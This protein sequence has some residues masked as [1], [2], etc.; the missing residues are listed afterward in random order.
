MATQA[1]LRAPAVALETVIVE[2]RALLGDRVSTTTATREQHGHDESWHHPAMPDAVCFVH[3]TAEVAA[4]VKACN[5]HRVPV[6]AYGQDAFPAFWSADSGLPAPLRMD[7]AADIAASHRMRA[8][9]GLP[10]G[11]LIANPIPAQH[12]IPPSELTPIIAEATQNAQELGIAGK[13]VTPF[14]LRR[15]FDLTGGRSLNAN[16]ALVL[17][18]AA[19][20]ARIAAELVKQDE[21]RPS[22]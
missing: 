5:T 9:L 20:A 7:S 13:D 1:T 11:Q 16:I 6:I 15:I 18:N 3:G 10:G 4:I 17:N 8:D 22:G 12:E 2:I 19:L 21:T 14:L